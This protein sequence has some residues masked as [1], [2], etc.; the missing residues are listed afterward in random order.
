MTTEEEEEEEEEREGAVRVRAECG[1]VQ[2]EEGR[3][4][5]RVEERNWRKVKAEEEEEEEEDEDDEDGDERSEPCA[6]HLPQ[7]DAAAAALC[8]SDTCG[9]SSTENSVMSQP[10]VQ[11]SSPGHSVLSRVVMEA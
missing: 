6:A 1:G 3:G 8:L 11:R 7:C 4:R 10:R 9:W 5:G 2:R